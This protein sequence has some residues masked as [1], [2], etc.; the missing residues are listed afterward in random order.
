VGR[1]AVYARLG[2][3]DAALADYDTLIDLLRGTGCPIYLARMRIQAR[4]SVYRPQFKPDV[5]RDVQRAIA[6]APTRAEPLI[7]WGDWLR[8]SEEHI[9]AL[10]RY[11][12][13][14]DKLLSSQGEAAGDQVWLHIAMLA[15]RALAYMAL[16]EPTRARQALE[17]A[18][19]LVGSHVTQADWAAE[20]PLGLE[21]AWAVWHGTRTVE[22]D[23]STQVRDHLG[24]V[25]QAPDWTALSAADVIQMRETLIALTAHGPSLGPDADIELL[26]AMARAA[27]FLGAPDADD[28]AQALHLSLGDLGEVRSRELRAVLAELGDLERYT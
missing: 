4:A 8:Q 3:L 24:R 26:L 10:E 23:A 22:R 1:G 27:A 18:D 9:G 17:E 16:S 19:Q 11:A 21:V 28:L 7:A 2:D 13:A 15:G 5:E 6:D 12:Q 14:E 25:S 20:R